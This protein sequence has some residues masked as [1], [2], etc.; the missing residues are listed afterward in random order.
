MK[1]VIRK[2]EIWLLRKN[3]IIKLENEVVV[4]EIVFAWM[5]SSHAS[6]KKWNHI[7][8]MDENTF[9][10]KMKPTLNSYHVP[11]IRQVQG[12][13]EMHNIYKTTF[14]K[15]NFLHTYKNNNSF[16]VF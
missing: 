2:G 6:N 5:K 3:E 4:F 1:L 15:I 13:E 9:Y 10:W 14:S 11:K 16:F 7:Q 8:I 12:G